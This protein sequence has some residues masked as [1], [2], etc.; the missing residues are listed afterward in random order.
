MTTIFA[1]WPSALAV[2]P[3]SVTLEPLTVKSV[4][5]TSAFGV[6]T[7][8]PAL[9]LRS[10]RRVSVRLELEVSSNFCGSVLPSV[11]GYS[12]TRVSGPVTGSVSVSV[13]ATASAVN[14][15]K[16][17]NA[18]AETSWS[19]TG[20]AVK[21]SVAEVIGEANES[22]RV[23]A[24]KTILPPASCV[25]AMRVVSSVPER[26]LSLD[27][28][29]TSWST[30]LPASRWRMS[31]VRVKGWTSVRFTWI[32]EGRL[33]P[34]DRYAIWLPSRLANRSLGAPAAPGRSP[35]GTVLRPATIADRKALAFVE[36]SGPPWPRTMP[37]A[38]S[39]NAAPLA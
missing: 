25:V 39:S 32:S 23:P 7:A 11:V 27:P 2:E 1:S 12:T 17:R 34:V 6:L 15:V 8:T 18:T 14:A 29:T 38:S 36:V 9:L 3:T 37:T 26:P 4:P 22:V 21:V 5:R 10:P 30:A 35:A 19:S 13:F 16:R 24:L 28:S 31:S 20:A 33:S